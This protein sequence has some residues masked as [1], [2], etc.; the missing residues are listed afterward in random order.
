MVFASTG[1]HLYRGSQRGQPLDV[2]FGGSKVAVTQNLLDIDHRYI[3]FCQ[4]ACRQ[5]P[6]RMKPERFDSSP[7]AESSHK[8]L[9]LQICT[10]FLFPV[11]E[12]P[13][14]LA[15]LETI[16]A[17]HRRARPSGP[18]QALHIWPIIFSN[19]PLNNACSSEE[20]VAVISSVRRRWYWWC[21]AK[22]PC[23][24]SVRAIR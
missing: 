6:D 18:E 1:K 5:M 15:T 4:Y 14:R 9:S 22:S 20:R 23:P 11:P 12:K 17:R 16:A 10:A 21:S 7:L 13:T 19:T 8:M 24:F 3:R 2:P